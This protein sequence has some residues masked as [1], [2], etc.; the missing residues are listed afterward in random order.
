MSRKTG[1]NQRCIKYKLLCSINYLVAGWG[2]RNRTSEWRNQNP[3]PYRLATPQYP[4]ERAAPN[5]EFVR[6]A[7]TIAAAP[8]RINARTGAI[9]GIN[10]A[11]S[12][13]R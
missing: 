9:Y 8:R 10:A 12:G 3:L 13:L 1:R 4:S 5:H 6:A 2:G 7:R 11:F